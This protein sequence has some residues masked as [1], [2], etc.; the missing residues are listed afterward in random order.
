MPRKAFVADLQEAID[1]ELTNNIFDLRPGDEDG[2]FRFKYEPPGGGSQVIKLEAQVTE[3]GDYPSAH[4]YFIYTASESIPRPVSEALE[5]FSIFDGMKVVPMLCKVAK[6]LNKAIAGSRL[7]PIQL[8]EGGMGI[9]SAPESEDSEEIDGSEEDEDSMEYDD[10]GEYSPRSSRYD[11]PSTTRLGNASSASTRTNFEYNSRIRTDLRITKSAGFRVGYLGNLLN[12]GQD[13]FVTIACRISKLGIPD[14]ALKAWHLDRSHYLVLLI[15]YTAGYRTMDRLKEEDWS[16]GSL[17]IYMRVGTSKRYK[18]TLLEALDAFTEIQERGKRKSESKPKDIADEDTTLDLS[19]GLHSLF[20]G[21]PLNELLNQRLLPI[22][23]YRLALGLPWSG[24]E[25]YYNDNQ[26]RDIGHSDLVPD[27]LFAL[28]NSRFTEHLPELVTSDHLTELSGGTLST[29]SFPLLAMQFTL[30]H[31]VR[32]T[33]FCL[34]CH[35]KVETDFEALKPYVCSRP[36]CLWQYMVRNLKY[37][38]NLPS[39]TEPT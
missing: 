35:C 4:G 31:L 27:K 12:Y 37:P 2:S 30:R 9:D 6:T 7:H 20:I 17:P 32:C 39:Q 36:L 33:E 1:T 11:F 25:A 15:H 18:V 38:N 26:G 34:V 3:V 14:E 19:T 8:D 10:E 16:H 29:L 24:A 21:R 23:R 5:D 28:D 22:L 13:S